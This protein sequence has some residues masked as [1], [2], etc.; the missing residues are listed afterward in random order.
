MGAVERRAVDV[1]AQLGRLNDGVLLRV[2][3]VA[4]LMPRAG[5]NPE[6]FAQALAALH[7][8]ADPCGR[9]VVAGGHHALILDDHRADLALLLIAARPRRNELRHFHKTMI[10]LRKHT[11]SFFCIPSTG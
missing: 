2:H 11:V 3:R 5:R 6:L 9:T 1:H 7:A 10:P 8:G 4:H